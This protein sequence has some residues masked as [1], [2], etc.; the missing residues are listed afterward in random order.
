MRRDWTMEGWDVMLA[1]SKRPHK[2][3]FPVFPL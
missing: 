2:A 1:Q 3:A